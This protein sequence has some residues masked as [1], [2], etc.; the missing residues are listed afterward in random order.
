[1]T[2]QAVHYGHAQALREVRQVALD[3]VFRATPNRFKGCRPTPHELPTAAW[4]N[5]PASERDTTTK[6]EL[7]TVNS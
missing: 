7:C 6:N 2:P 1:M 5:P 3:T 4:I